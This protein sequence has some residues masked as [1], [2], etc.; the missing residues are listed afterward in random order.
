MY[1]R[2][3]ANK[4]ENRKLHNNHGNVVERVCARAKICDR[5]ISIG[6]V[7]ITFCLLK[8]SARNILIG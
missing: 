6:F 5:D 3:H 1:D 2:P 7:V 4:I 8:N